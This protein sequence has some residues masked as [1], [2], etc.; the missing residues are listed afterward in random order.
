MIAYW[1]WRILTSLTNPIMNHPRTRKMK[2]KNA[3]PLDWYF[4]TSRN[5]E[6]SI[7]RN[8]NPN[9]FVLELAISTRKR[10][11]YK[12]KRSV[13]F[14][15]SAIGVC[16][17]YRKVSLIK[18]VLY[19]VWKIHTNDHS[20]HFKYILRGVNYIHG[21]L[22]YAILVRNALMINGLFSRTS[23]LLSPAAATKHMV[24]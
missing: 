2:R 22:I 14:L 5:L 16:F 17:S 10:I 3:N 19:I 15:E 23:R 21:I 4:A 13:S 20:C 8:R 6:V 18:I 1:T 11:S 7:L 24:L 9:E 12:R